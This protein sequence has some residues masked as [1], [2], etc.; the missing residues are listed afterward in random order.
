MPPVLLFAQS[1]SVLN[2]QSSAYD[3]VGFFGF[4]VCAV[5]YRWTVII[6]VSAYFIS[7]ESGVNEWFNIYI[8]GYISSSK[9]KI[10]SPS[11]T[12]F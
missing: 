9:R 5:I 4:T 2:R 1:F 11:A 10:G 6:T 8:T 7:A 12:F 3:P